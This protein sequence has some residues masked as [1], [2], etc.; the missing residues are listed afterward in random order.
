MIPMQ[1]DIKAIAEIIGA[2]SVVLG[3]VIGGYKLYDKICDRLSEL[4]KRVEK[5]ETK[6]AK[7]I[8]RIN[9]ENALIILALRGCL[10]GLI[11]QGCNGEC[12][13]AK[14]A[15]DEFINKAAHD[16]D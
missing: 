4:E 5:V 13:K 14:E 6:H 7:D 11:Q 15:L 1:I 9:Q 2:L 16:Q 8:D 3:V 10:D 12:K